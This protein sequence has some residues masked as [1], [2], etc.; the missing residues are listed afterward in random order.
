M[1]ATTTNETSMIGAGEAARLIGVST[2]YLRQLAT[3]GR[4]RF[5]TTPYGRAYYLDDAERVRLERLD[6]E[7]A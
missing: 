2:E 6:R 1:A 3:A 7:A 5:E 4:I